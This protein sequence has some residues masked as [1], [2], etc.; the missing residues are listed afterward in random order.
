[1]TG[2]DGKPQVKEALIRDLLRWCERR[3]EPAT[4]PLGACAP[5]RRYQQGEL[6]ETPAGDGRRYLHD[7]DGSQTLNLAV[8]GSSRENDAPNPVS[9]V[10]TRREMAPARGRSKRLRIKRQASSRTDHDNWIKATVGKW[11]LT[12]WGNDG[13]AIGKPPGV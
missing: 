7:S 1:M 3:T 10:G 12:I 9:K 5:R 2:P 4:V 11:R 13:V 6:P 8:L